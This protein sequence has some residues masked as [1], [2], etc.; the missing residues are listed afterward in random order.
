MKHSKHIK[1]LA[2]AVLGIAAAALSAGISADAAESNGFRY[3]Y[4]STTNEATVTGYTGSSSTPSIPSY[5]DGHKVTAIGEDAFL[6]ENVTSVTIPGTVKSI[7]LYAFYGSDLTSITL[8]ASVTA[9]DPYA[10]AYCSSLAS[11]KINGAA[12]LDWCSFW[13]CAA[14]TNVQASASSKTKPSECAFVNC[15]SLSKVNG[16]TVVSHQTDSSGY[17]YPVLNSSAETA[18]RN[19]FSRSI[20]VKFVN[21]YCTDL[22]KYIVK[23][24]TSYDPD[25]PENQPGD[26]MTDA[27]KARQLHDWLVRHCEYEDSNGSERTGDMENHVASAIFL[28]Y[29]YNVRGAGIGEAVCDGYAKAY[30]MLLTAARIESYRV[31]T[32]NHAWNV[33]KVDDNYYQVDVTWDDPIIYSGGTIIDNTY[34]NP[35]STTYTYFLKSHADM[36]AEHGSGQASPVMTQPTLNEHPL[37][38]EYSAGSTNY[39]TLCTASFDDSNHDGMLDNDFDLDGTAFGTDYWEDMLAHSMLCGRYF[40]YSVDLNA[41]LPQVLSIMHS[42]HHGVWG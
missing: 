5:L 32:A 26:W 30:T 20:D 24:E 29:A 2:A 7:G 4:N 11:V 13:N 39:L 37:L 14:L 12:V 31:N 6:F 41:L 1:W 42:E 15:P 27:Q 40:N 23:T 34:G 10:F 9:V 33:V 17:Q 18:I 16:V 21:D 35:Y 19:H 36:I 8:P 3:T 28:S 38:D 25:G 22:C